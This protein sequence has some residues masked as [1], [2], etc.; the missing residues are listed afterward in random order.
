MK[1]KCAICNRER[2]RKS[3]RIFVPT[4]QEK[5]TLKKMGENPQAEYGYCRPCV[6]LMQ[7]PRTAADVMKGVMQMYARA[8]GAVNPDEVAERFKNRLLSKTPMKPVS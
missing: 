7:D 8:F 2:D 3:C 4:P 5:N 1:I 6:R